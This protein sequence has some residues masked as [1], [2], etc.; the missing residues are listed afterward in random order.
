MCGTVR[1]E[2]PG[3]AWKGPRG[4]EAEG[5]GEAWEGPQGQEAEGPGEVWEGPRGREA[6]GPGEAWRA[7]VQGCEGDPGVVRP[8][9]GGGVPGAGCGVRER[10]SPGQWGGSA[11]TCHVP[12]TR[13]Y[14]NQPIN[15]ETASDCGGRTHHMYFTCVLIFHGLTSVRCGG[16]T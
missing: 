14:Q 10:R 12:S 4:Q 1:A 3:E 13:G 6:E 9:A 15:V 2:V 7:R 16:G 5:P 8:P 11:K